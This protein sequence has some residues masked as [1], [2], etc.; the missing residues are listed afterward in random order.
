MTR[1]MHRVL[2]IED[3]PAV[4]KVLTMLFETNGFRA[5]SADMCELA[6]R[7]AR[8]HRPDLCIVDL[9]LP[10]HDGL[11]F[12][13]QVRTWSLV[14]IIVLTARTQE[15]QRVAAFD[16]GADD[17]VIKPF[18]SLELLARVRA[19]LR[20][21]VRIDQSQLTLRLGTAI[22][23]LGKRVTRGPNGEDKKLSPLEHRILECLI[24]HADGIA[25]HTQLLQEV[26]GPHQSDIRALRV[27]IA[28]LRGK[29]ERDPARPC[30]IL[31]EPGVGYRLVTDGQ[32]PT[33]EPEEA[34]DPTAG[35]GALELH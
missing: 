31:T 2:V 25:T 19:I 32:S 34:S 16:G 4:R 15:T 20:R 7:Q 24:R 33:V 11:H 10:D 21:S 28:S 26:W 14:P 3:D 12:I 6:V 35:E 27:Y 1:A 23:D 18:S 5:I 8:S 13:R 9:G 17:Y 30:H 22:I 29:L